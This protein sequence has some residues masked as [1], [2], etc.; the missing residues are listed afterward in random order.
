MTLKENRFYN[1]NTKK[2]KKN[3]SVH[4]MTGNTPLFYCPTTVRPY[5]VEV[6]FFSNLIVLLWCIV[7]IF[8]FYLLLK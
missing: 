8:H 1:K 4:A 2:D 3:F 6:F 5:F 7:T